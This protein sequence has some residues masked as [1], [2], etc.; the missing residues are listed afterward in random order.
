LKLIE[1]QKSKTGAGKKRSHDAL[2]NDTAPVTGKKSRTDSTKGSKAKKTKTEDKE[3]YDVSDIHLEGEESRCV[4]VFDA[5]ADLRRKISAHERKG[6]TMEK[7][8]LHQGKQD[9]RS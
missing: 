5:C 9:A 6:V 4:P 1:L 3:K 7:A 2:Q 8:M